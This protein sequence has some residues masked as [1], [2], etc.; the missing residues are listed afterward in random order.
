[1]TM[2]LIDLLQAAGSSERPIESPELGR[3]D[4]RDL[5]HDSQRVSPGTVFVAL[6]GRQ[7][8]GIRFADDAVARGAVAII[9]DAMGADRYQAGGRELPVP[10]IT[11]TKPRAAMA[12]LAAHLHGNPCE[13]LA[14]LGVTGTN[15]KTSVSHLVQSALLAGGVP[16]GV[17]GTLGTS[18][19]GEQLFAGTRTTPESPDL[20]RIC[21]QM[22][23]VGA[24]A[25][26][27]EVSSIA[28]EEHRVDG[29][30]FDAVGFTGLSHD[31]LDYHGSMEAYFEAK[32]RL[33]T[34]AYSKGGV[35]VVDDHWGQQLVRQ[36]EVPVVTVSTTQVPADW[37]IQR[38]GATAEVVGPESASLDLSLSTGFVAA[39]ALL[40]IALAYTQ[41]IPVGVSA[42][43]VS[44]AR[45]PGR[46][47][48]VARVDGIDFVVDYAHSPDSIDQVV[49]DAAQNRDS[50]GGR[51]IVVFG[52]GGDRDQQKR[53]G[54]GRSA[55]SAD[56][57]IVTDD[58]PRSEDPAEIRRAV[59][60][61]VEGNRTQVEE[62]ASRRQAIG[63]AVEIA[64]SGDVVLVLGKGHESTQEIAGEY[65]PFDDREV[66][67]SFVRDRFG[68]VGIAEGGE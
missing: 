46:M 26:A 21:A 22:V 41:G 16:T 8:H 40:S 44:R 4:V 17:I 12:R 18:F 35:V 23:A 10:V 7:T 48:R 20:Q 9:T 33:F 32:A 27:M 56:V 49:G 55:A 39:N 42:D 68:S 37:M 5:T 52:A 13:Q 47:E 14:M 58:N 45:V 29:I 28:V 62:I 66:L 11:L 36:T 30:T 1:V 63:R 6:P 61:G 31:H 54:M 65:L 50:R 15:G 59:R 60:R 38:I 25:V 24:R 43:A 67:A 3:V 57:V 64:E 51:V 53:P 34:P 2:R 19:A